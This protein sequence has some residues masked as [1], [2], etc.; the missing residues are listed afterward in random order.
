MRRLVLA[1]IAIARVAAADDPRDDE[2]ID[3]RGAIPD[4]VL[5]IR[6]A[7]ADNFTGK[8][9]YPVARC[10]LRRAVVARLARVARALRARDRRRG[11]R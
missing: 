5:D 10:K 8:E 9:L 4:A 3:V 11:S 1:S 7:T 2:L 6:Y